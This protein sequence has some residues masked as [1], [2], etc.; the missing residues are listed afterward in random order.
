MDAILRKGNLTF[1]KG[2]KMWGIPSLSLIR[3]AFAH[4]M[5]HH[6]LPE[7]SS[8][9]KRTGPG[10]GDSVCLAEMDKN[11][12]LFLKQTKFR[13]RYFPASRFNQTDG[14]AKVALKAVQ[15]F[16]SC[17]ELAVHGEAFGF[18]KGSLAVLRRMVTFVGRYFADTVDKPTVEWLTTEAY[19]LGVDIEKHPILGQSFKFGASL[20]L[21]RNMMTINFFWNP[22]PAQYVELVYERENKT[23]KNYINDRQNHRVGSMLINHVETQRL[24]KD[25]DFKLLGMRESV[26]DPGLGSGIIGNISNKYLYSARSR[27]LRIAYDTALKRTAIMELSIAENDNDEIQEADDINIDSIDAVADANV[28]NF[29]DSLFESND[30][31]N[32]DDDSKSD[33][34]VDID[35]IGDGID[36]NVNIPDHGDASDFKVLNDHIYFDAVNPVSCQEWVKF[37]DRHWG[38]PYPNYQ[39]SSRTRFL[40]EIWDALWKVLD[41]VIDWPVNSTEIEMEVLILRYLTTGQ[42]IVT[43][44][45][46]CKLFYHAYTDCAI[47][48]DTVH[49]GKNRLSEYY[50]HES[51]YFLRLTGLCG[52]PEFANSI[53]TL[54]AADMN[55]FVAS[56]GRVWMPENTNQS[57]NLELYSFESSPVIVRTHEETAVSVDC[58]IQALYVAHHHT[59][60]DNLHDQLGM[61]ELLPTWSHDTCSVIPRMM[62]A[63]TKIDDEADTDD[64]AAEQGWKYQDWVSSQWV[65]QRSAS[66]NHCRQRRLGYCG[67]SY[68]CLVC[69]KYNV[70]SCIRLHKRGVSVAQCLSS[71]DNHFKV[72]STYQGYSC[73]WFSS[74]SLNELQ[75]MMH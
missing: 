37:N 61:S 41:T 48:L 43:R 54:F 33:D 28:D 47:G 15:V 5:F 52:I 69:N 11:W 39:S 38:M 63:Y 30:D 40:P 22:I 59:L 14:A 16:R 19:S 50:I 62:A 18:D 13:P 71:I 24:L 12:Q 6:I 36:G 58:I 10:M 73:R 55:D 31:V 64:E 70:E 49:W 42:L 34:N 46:G 56:V 66:T 4:M 45:R 51:N 26:N 8:A 29:D 2:P 67:M 74:K 53:D 68:H 65:A 25:W 21:L 60:P 44:G 9:I 23:S 27:K 17:F 35:M 75:F 7:L 20:R 3:V 57:L 72:Y 1:G 32:M